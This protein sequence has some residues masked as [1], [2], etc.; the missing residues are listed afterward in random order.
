MRLLAAGRAASPR[1]ISPR[2]LRACDVRRARWLLVAGALVLGLIAAGCGSMQPASQAPAPARLSK[3]QRG[4]P[5]PLTAV[6]AQEGRLLHGGQAT[7]KAR[8]ASLIGYPVVVNVW[9]SW[10]LP[11]RAEFPLFQ[12]ASAE[13]GRQVAFLG[14]NALDQASAAQGFPGQVSGELSQLPG[15]R[16]RLTRTL[17]AGAGVPVTAFFDRAGRISF[18]HQGAYS[19]ERSLL[20]DVARYASQ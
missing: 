5:P 9:A 3:L 17:G 19:N 18:L 6:H 10:C 8:I 13:L 15:P 4:S 1:K 7:F 2:P 11:C 20:Q 16:R 12:S 14:V